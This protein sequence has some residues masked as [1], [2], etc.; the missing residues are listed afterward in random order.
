M[1]KNSFLLTLTI[2]LLGF[3]YANAKNIQITKFERNY[4]S[5][6]AS[7]NPV[8]DNAGDACAVIRFW[9]S[10]S[11]YITYQGS[12]WGSKFSSGRDVHPFEAYMKTSSGSTRSISISDDMTTGIEEI[13]VLENVD[14]TL[15]VYDL[16]GQLLIV[17][18][19]K[20]IDDVK[21]LLPAGVYIVSGKKLIIK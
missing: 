20:S 8:F 14:N 3:G 16:K 9:Y 7:M 17:E 5:L 12:D 11:D 4:T 13:P 2:A 15:K 6:I 19:G 18:T 1:K 10:G 21:H